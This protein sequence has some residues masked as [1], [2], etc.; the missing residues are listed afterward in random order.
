MSDDP[1]DRI[2]SRKDDLEPSSGFARNVM[3]AVRRE[4]SAP[5]PIPFPWKRALPG[6][7]LC[8]LA[9]AAMCVAALVQP[10]AQPL[11]EVPGPSIWT[12]M[13][14]AAW[15]GLTSLVELLRAA[16]VG[17]LGWIVLA[18]LLTLASVML[19]LRLIGRRV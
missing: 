19:S 14:T 16:N 15:T 13:W 9:L 17:G 12:A 2:L 4:A 5:A 11:H 3:D 7:V 6:L 8:V 10:A 1:L 18:L